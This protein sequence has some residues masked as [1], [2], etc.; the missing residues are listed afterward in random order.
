MDSMIQVIYVMLIV[1]GKTCKIL[2][3]FVYAYVW[4][5]LFHCFCLSDE[6][7]SGIGRPPRFLWW[8]SLL[9]VSSYQLIKTFPTNSRTLVYFTIYHFCF[10]FHS[11]NYSLFG[12]V[13][14]PRGLL[15]QLLT[16]SLATLSIFLAAR[17][18]LGPI[19]GPGGTVF[20]LLVL[21]VL[22]L[23]GEAWSAKIAC[24]KFSDLNQL[25]DLAALER[26]ANGVFDVPGLFPDGSILIFFSLLFN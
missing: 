3:L 6:N 1:L 22:A 17:T 4:V 5:F 19:A 11:F 15:A 13:C 16:L 20:A 23:I 26:K 7:F 25:L 12:V 8:R 10:L 21:I 24:A 9:Q 18:M 14:P 2:H